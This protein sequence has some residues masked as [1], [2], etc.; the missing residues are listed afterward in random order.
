MPR[1]V[2]QKTPISTYRLQI[3]EGFDLTQAAEVTDYIASLGADWVYLS[4]IL[5]AEKGS[6]H[7]YDVTDHSRVD[8]ERGGEGAFRALSTSARSHGLGVLVD[9]VPNHVGVATPVQSV[10]WW[11]VLEK[12]RD[13]RYAEAFDVDW[14]FG[15]GKLRIPVLGDDDPADA[16]G[17]LGKLELKTTADGA[18]RLFYY[19][20]EYPVAEGTAPDGADSDPVRVH[21]AQSY[22]LVN[23][24]RADAE[25]NYRRFFAVNTL[26]AIRVEVPWVFAESHETIVG[27]IRDGL[28]DGLRADHPDGLRDPGAYLD[29][30]AEATGGAYVLIE[31]ILA[32]HRGV[33]E[34]MPAHWQTDGTTGYDALATIDRVFV[35]PAGEQALDA[36]D[37]RL[38]GTDPVVWADMIHDGKREVTDGILGSEVARLAREVA[39]LLDADAGGGSGADAHEAIAEL[40]ACFPV[41]RSYLAAPVEGETP[42]ETYSDGIDDLYTAADSARRRRPELADAIDA[43]VPVLSDPTTDV[44]KRFQQTS[45]MVMAKGVEDR[46]FYRWTRLTTLTEVGAE[47]D[48]FAVDVAEFHARQADRLENLPLSMTTLSTHDTKRSEDVRARIS[49]LAE[50]PDEWTQALDALREAVGTSDGPFD[51]LLAQA[52]VGS[53][54]TAAVLADET[55]LAEYRKRL[56]AYA[57]KAS[58][59][60]ET[61][62][63]WT[64]ADEEYE[65]TM[66]AFVDATLDDAGARGVV[67][68]I[69]ERVLGAGRS[70]SLGVK[71]LQ[72]TGPGVPDVYQGSELW[73][74]SLVDPDNRRP[75]DYAERRAILAAIDD[76]EVPAIDDSG[77]AK[78]LVT[79][80]TLRLR[81]DRSDLFGSYTPLDVEG[82]AADHLVAVAY[83]DGGSGAIALATRLPLGLA[84]RGGWGD[85]TVT[86]PAGSYVDVLTGRGVDGIEEVAQLL[87]LLPVALLAPVP[88]DDTSDD[89]D[90]SDE[91]LDETGS[92]PASHSSSTQ[93]ADHS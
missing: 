15:N 83:G 68:R 48:E 27:W 74:L 70:N 6:T 9:I 51:N 78:L 46:S 31:K 34:R 45:G 5:Q 52:I 33:A 91:T 65:K 87:D 43:L 63:A 54:P 60:A 93:K 89:S 53:W 62:T 86:I 79:A 47:P 12:G 16:G 64:A 61:S 92:D 26:A 80:S 44:A 84:E 19:D 77:A 23:W 59:E 75:V 36:L 25:L 35:D 22:E 81:R 82:S 10:W 37:T 49:V 29:A 41:Y 18:L 40:L 38:R 8:P 13:S 39:P 73:D 55:A 7:G 20:T 4:P 2:P 58:R 90:S 21:A 67:E 71:L 56:H 3:H 28:A 66:H 50:I 17:E 1:P 30:L 69:V 76:G 72:I 11:D 24:R 57:E 14:D 85:T 32:R 42:T 88:D